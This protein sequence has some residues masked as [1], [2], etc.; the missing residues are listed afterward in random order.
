MKGVTVVGQKRETPSIA[1]EETTDPNDGAV[2]ELASDDEAESVT[3]VEAPDEL[4]E[5]TLT[6]DGAVGFGIAPES[7]K[8]SVATG[9]PIASPSRYILALS[10]PSF[11]VLVPAE[12][13][14]FE[15]SELPT[16][17]SALA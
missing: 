14:G 5:G 17:T 1:P 15:I 8:L 13:I 11:L 7:R 3:D 12:S 6:D 16:E 2:D 9:W 4:L 10:R